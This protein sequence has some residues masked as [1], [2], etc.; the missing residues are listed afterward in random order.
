MTRLMSPRARLAAAAVL[1]LA[2]G[3]GGGLLAGRWLPAAKAPTA[4]S[5]DG[6]AVLYWYDPMVPDQHFDAPGKSPFMDMQLVPRYADEAGA[7]PGVRI[8]PSRIQA[9]GVRFATARQGRLADDLTAT[10]VVDFNQRDIA[11]VQVRAAGFVQRTYNRAPGDI[12]VAGRRWPIC[13][14]RT[15]AGPRPS[16]WRCGAAA[17]IA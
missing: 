1:L 15:G 16:I 7:A 5:G 12:I 17:T 9:L 3:L 11:V 10:A 2:V 14:S 6:R 8:D 13:S 4:A